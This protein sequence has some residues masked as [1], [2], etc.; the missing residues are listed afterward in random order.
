[1]AINTHIKNWIDRSDPDYYIMFIKA[2]IPYNAWYMHNFYNED[3]KCTSD[4]SIIRYI[5]N[6]PNKYKDKIISL[7]N[8]NDDDSEQFKQRI[9]L[10]HYQLESHSVPDYDNRI[11][12]NNICIEDN[13]VRT[14][15]LPSGQYSIK[16]MNDT[17]LPK[18]SPR[19]IF[20]VIKNKTSVT[21]HRIALYK[22]SLTELHRN[23]D[24][25]EIGNGKIKSKIEECLNEI[26]PKKTISI[27]LKPNVNGDGSYSK[28]KNCIT[29]DDNKNLYFT[30]DTDKISKSIIQ[31]IYDL[32]CKL[33]HGELDP[34]NANL[35]IYEQAFYIQR[36]LIKELE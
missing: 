34:T 21:I 18:T 36:M 5:Q 28:P 11:S 26:N 8:G 6:N 33:F 16:G 9:T 32:R 7:I 14:K 27:V 17:S 3:E 10:L 30:N 2:W 25:K 19:W 15:V 1:M 22:C 4:K 12:F 24:Y 29:I 20:E 35:G 31:I 23:T 13:T